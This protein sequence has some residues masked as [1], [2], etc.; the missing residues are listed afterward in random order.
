[1]SKSE[2]VDLG[3]V[4]R[5]AAWFVKNRVNIVHTHQPAARIYAGPAARLAGALLVNTLHGKSP[6]IWRRMLLRRAATQLVDAFVVVSPRLTDFA[7]EVERAEPKKIVVIENGVDVNR[8]RP[9]DGERARIRHMLG[10][11]DGEWVIGTAARLSPEKDQATLLAATAPLLERGARLIIAGD[12]PERSQ[13]ETLARSLGIEKRV[14]FLGMVQ[15]V[16]QFLPALDVFALSSRRE[17]LPLSMLEAMATGIPVVAT[18]VGGIPNAL[19]EGH[20]G[21]LVRPGDAGAL[22]AGLERL[23]DQPSE[24][25]VLGARGRETVIERFSSRKMQDQYSKLY[26]DLLEAAA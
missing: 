25:T 21:V 22:R 16:S 12:G 14:T 6:E 24:A 10:A 18:S 15:D 19:H 26:R 23:R 7:Q 17:G 11:H 1:M 20:S 9:A 13:L 5:F 2:G 4:P 3:L 8:F